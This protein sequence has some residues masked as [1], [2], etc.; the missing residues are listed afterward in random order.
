LQTMLFSDEVQNAALQ[1]LPMDEPISALALLR[2]PLRGDSIPKGVV[3]SLAIGELRSNWGQPT[4]RVCLCC[5]KGPT[6]VFS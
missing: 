1:C 2:D 6:R 3:W 5:S 4:A